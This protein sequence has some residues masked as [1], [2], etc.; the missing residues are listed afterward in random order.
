MEGHNKGAVCVTGGTGFVASW[1]IMKLLE[2]GY[3]VH[4][5]VRSSEPDKKKDISFLTNL[6]GATKRLQIFNADLYIPGSFDAAI[7]G[8]IGVFHVAF[9]MDFEDKETEE[10]K[11]KK[12][13]DGTLSILK[14]CLESKTVKRVVCTSSASTVFGQNKGLDVLDESTWTDVDFVRALKVVGTSYTI[15]KTSIERAALEFAEKHGLDL[16]TVIPPFIHGPFICPRLPDSVRSSMAMI[17][18][19]KDQ[20]N[21][22]VN[23]TLAHV[24]DVASAHIFLLE[25]PDAKGRYICAAVEITIQEMAKFLSSRYPEY[26]IPTADCLKEIRGIKFPGL[27]SKKL[28]DIGFKYKHGLEDM[29]DGA[30]QCCKQ[31]GFL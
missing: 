22:L 11:T 13:I 16:V 29:Y 4:A 18:G 28:L 19:D 24:D 1:L 6:P 2:Q 3:S 25:H 15:A 12:A 7:A 9:P 30:I 27:S 23:T 14:A 5:T 10:T 20:Y 17:F 8:C 26:Q 31:K 21:Y